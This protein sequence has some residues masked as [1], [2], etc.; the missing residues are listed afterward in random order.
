MQKKFDNLC[1]QE[2]FKE[3]ALFYVIN[4]NVFWDDLPDKITLIALKLANELGEERKKNALFIL[5]NSNLIIYRKLTLES[6]PI[7]KFMTDFVHPLLTKLNEDFRDYPTVPEIMMI[8]KKSRVKFHDMERDM[9]RMINDFKIVKQKTDPLIETL[10][11]T[12]SSLN[13]L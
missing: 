9:Q 10:K 13:T 3:A 7:A 8:C 4:E 2:N 5:I 12:L 11:E 1:D 6:A